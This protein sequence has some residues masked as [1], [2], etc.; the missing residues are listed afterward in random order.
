MSGQIKYDSP[1]E[2]VS[3]FYFCFRK[4]SADLLLVRQLLNV[5]K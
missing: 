1:D 5:L 3:A 2:R 4:N